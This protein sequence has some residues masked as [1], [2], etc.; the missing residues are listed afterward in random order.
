MDRLSNA[1]G[2]EQAREQAATYEITASAAQA[3]LQAFEAEHNAGLEAIQAEFEDYQKHPLWQEYNQKKLA[4]RDP[5]DTY[6]GVFWEE[7]RPSLGWKR[8]VLYNGVDDSSTRHTRHRGR[9]N[10]GNPDQ[11]ILP[12]TVEEFD[13][14]ADIAERIGQVATMLRDHSGEPIVSIAGYSGSLAFEKTIKSKVGRADDRY[15]YGYVDGLPKTRAIVGN[16][17]QADDEPVLTRQRYSEGD[18]ERDLRLKLADNVSGIVSAYSLPTSKRQTKRQTRLPYYRKQSYYSKQKTLPIGNSVDG[19]LPLS[20]LRGRDFLIID[21]PHSVA[22]DYDFPESIA[23]HRPKQKIET[24]GGSRD[25][26]VTVTPDKGVKVHEATVVSEDKE[27]TLPALRH[28]TIWLV[29]ARAIRDNLREAVFDSTINTNGERGT[30]FAILF[31][32]T[33]LITM[34]NDGHPIRD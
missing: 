26:E 16:I 28:D 31:A 14:R 15:T 19:D 30:D 25:Q 8:E 11:S 24:D 1:P 2:V 27:V 4:T 18:E 10:K 29:G 12:L 23:V 22:A 13:R 32:V 21:G 9:L 7:Q 20:H 6:G 17:G 3:E 34:A 33:D 5:A